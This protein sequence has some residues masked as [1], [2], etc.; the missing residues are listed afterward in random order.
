[1][2]A[3]PN[4]ELIEEQKQPPVPDSFLKASQVPKEQ[5]WLKIFERVQF[6]QEFN[7]FI[8]ID[9]LSN[10]QESHKRWLGYVESQ[11]RRL[12]Q[13]LNDNKDIGELRI[14]PKAFKREETCITKDH[15]IK[16]FK[17]CDQYFI[18][19]RFIV[20]HSEDFHKFNL[21]DPVTQFCSLI[22]VGRL[23][24]DLNNL[25]IIHLKRDELPIKLIR[26]Y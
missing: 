4:P 5:S 1:M 19:I 26:K 21:R 22:E 24:K 18:G 17:C 2:M 6:F 9:I 23:K 14:L 15:I 10:D 25:R 11:I 12:F 16:D 8:K 3:E 7:H 20:S 13:L